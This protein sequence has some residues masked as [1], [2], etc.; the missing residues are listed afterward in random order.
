MFSDKTVLFEPLEIGLP[1]GLLASLS[2]VRMSGGIVLVP[3][4]NVSVLDAVL[5]PT[6][7]LGKL[8]VFFLD[9]SVGLTEVSMLNAWLAACDRIVA[10]GAERVENVE[11]QGLSDEEQ[12][13]VR[14]L[15]REFQSVFSSGERDLGYIN[16]LS[17]EIP[18]MDETPV[19]QR[20][21]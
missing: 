9:S 7:I 4:V 21:R 20:Y 12:E 2:L 17:H 5:Y 1:A 10:S 13:Q 6:M 15:L 3:I 19:R 8:R 16:L 14:A 11:L 18:L